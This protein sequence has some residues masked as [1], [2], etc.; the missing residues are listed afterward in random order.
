MINN[1]M[2]IHRNNTMT[3]ED[4]IGQHAEVDIDAIIIMADTD[5]TIETIT[6]I[7]IVAAEAEAA[8]DTIINNETTTTINDK[9]VI[10]ERDI[11]QITM[12]KKRMTK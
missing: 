9:A 12:S 6:T 7:K 2:I 5:T 4:M 8:M 10:K 3:I 1:I 11:M